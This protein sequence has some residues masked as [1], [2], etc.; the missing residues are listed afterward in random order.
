MNSKI[1]VVREELA[2]LPQVSRTWFEWDI[3]HDRQTRTLVVE[4]LFETDPNSPQF[5]QSAFEE[6]MHV[7][8]HALTSQTTVAVLAMEIAKQGIADVER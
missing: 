3:E 7:V 4:V 8:Q 5:N 6:I 1:A 2:R